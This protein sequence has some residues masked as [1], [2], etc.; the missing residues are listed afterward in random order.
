MLS[1]RLRRGSLAS[2]RPFLVILAHTKQGDSWAKQL[3]RVAR[4]KLRSSW[5]A[6]L[7]Q[8]FRW[9]QHGGSEQVVARGHVGGGWQ[10]LARQAEALPHPRPHLPGQQVR[11]PSPRRLQGKEAEFEE[12]VLQADQ[13]PSVPDLMQLLVGL[14]LLPPAAARGARPAAADNDRDG[15]GLRLRQ[16][17]AGD[18][19]DLR[20]GRRPGGVLHRHVHRLHLLHD[21]GLRLLVGQARERLRARR[22]QP[23][24]V[25]ALPDADAAGGD[26]E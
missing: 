8:L 9:P 23:A 16:Q 13:A 1:L 17:P 5:L 26:A 7:P 25:H 11:V 19:S 2:E 6:Q 20:R 10:L 4:H 18:G 24:V 21:V 22:G 15:R 14:L 12:E 3:V